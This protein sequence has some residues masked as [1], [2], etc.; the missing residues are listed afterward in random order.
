MMCHLIRLNKRQL[1]LT[2]H[3]QR[4]RIILERKKKFLPV[5]N[6]QIV[7]LYKIEGFSLY[8][9]VL[10]RLLSKIRHTSNGNSFIED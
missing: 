6:V 5:I 4:V 7:G 1:R 10:T 2:N 3:F 8:K 9:G